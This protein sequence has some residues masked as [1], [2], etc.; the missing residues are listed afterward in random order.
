[1]RLFNPLLLAAA[2]AS[3]LAAQ[4]ACGMELRNLRA[5]P[6]E[7]GVGQRLRVRFAATRFRWISIA[8]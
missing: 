2:T 3:A 6:A 1:M 8:N 7:P 5:D 4:P